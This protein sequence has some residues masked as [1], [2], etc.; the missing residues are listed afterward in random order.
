MEYTR[1]QKRLQKADQKKMYELINA[2]VNDS[3]AENVE[4][5]KNKYRMQWV[6][7]AKRINNLQRGY[8]LSYTAFDDNVKK[9]VVFP[10]KEKWYS[11]LFKFLFA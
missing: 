8:K 11:K 7:Y 3:T 1:H 5:M 6:I 4:E 10:A 2:F 9:E